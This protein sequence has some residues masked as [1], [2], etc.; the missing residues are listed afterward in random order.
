VQRTWGQRAVIVLLVLASLGSALVAVGLAE[1]ARVTSSIDRVPLSRALDPP[2][3]APDGDGEDGGPVPAVSFLVVGV[4]GVDGVRD[5]GSGPRNVLADS[6]IVVRT[7][8]AGAEILPLP[9]DLWGEIPGHGEAKLNAAMAYGANDGGAGA[10]QALLIE[11]IRQRFGLVINH[12][13]QV[14]FA[15]FVDLVDHVGGIDL[16]VPAPARDTH[17][18]LDL[19]GPACTHLDGDD[20]FRLARSRYYDARV[21]GD[22]TRDP[23]SELGRIRRQQVVLRAALTAAIDRGLR[24]PVTLRSMVTDAAARVTLDDAL[25]LPDLLDLAQAL[26]GVDVDAVTTLALEVVDARREGQSVLELVDS[27]ANEAVLDRFRAAPTDAPTTEPPPPTSTS[28]A[29]TGPATTAATTAPTP[30]DDALAPFTPSL[31]QPDGRPC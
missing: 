16:F 14:D 5:D 22:W 24:N 12:Y 29:T 8:P 2:T 1:V 23:T 25:S 10:G 30:A 4:D 26:R 17:A 31:V 15:A 7:T 19:A 3:P 9:R 18:G 20:A 21:D 11:T 28:P 27:A 6:M 13:V